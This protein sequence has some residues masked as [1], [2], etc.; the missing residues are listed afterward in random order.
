MLFLRL[1]LVM[2]HWLLGSFPLWLY[3]FSWRAFSSH[4]RCICIGPS[5]SYSSTVIPHLPSATS[6][7]SPSGCSGLHILHSPP[8]GL[9]F[10]F[11]KIAC[12]PPSNFYIGLFF[13]PSQDLL[14]LEISTFCDPLKLYINPSDNVCPS[15][16]FLIISRID[17]SLLLYYLLFI[18]VIK[19][20]NNL[21]KKGF[22]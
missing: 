21:E 12:L 19:T 15:V 10:M 18:A 3:S 13:E 6:L 7:D 9:A 2:G 5:P 22:I 4:P 20:L 14:H 17:F 16:P 11:Q 1:K 8:Q